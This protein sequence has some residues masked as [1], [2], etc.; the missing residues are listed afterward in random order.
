MAHLLNLYA[1][2]CNSNEPKSPKALC[3]VAIYKDEACKRPA[4]TCHWYMKNKPDRRNKWMMFNCF[5]YRLVW[6]ED[7]KDTDYPRLMAK[8]SKS[9]YWE[10]RPGIYNTT[11][12]VNGGGFYH[13]T[14]LMKSKGDHVYADYGYE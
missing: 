11:N 1:K 10:I 8:T 2:R 9:E 12:D 5:K 6:L 3:D 13:L 14:S 4:V 7:F